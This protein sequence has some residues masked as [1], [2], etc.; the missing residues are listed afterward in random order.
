LERR[1]PLLR[2]VGLLLRLPIPRVLVL[3]LL[4]VPLDPLERVD[5][6]AAAAAVEPLRL[7]VE[8]GAVQA[9]VAAA[10]D[11]VGLLRRWL[12]RVV[13]R[14][15]EEDDFGVVAH[16]SGSARFQVSAIR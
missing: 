8:P 15:R 3:P 6:D 4:D 2:L 9:V 11:V 13:V 5:L 7:D 14:T 10:E 1:E 12:D 16:R